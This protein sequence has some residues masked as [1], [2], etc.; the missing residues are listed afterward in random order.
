MHQQL[1][2]LRTITAVRLLA[3]LELH[4]ANDAAL[5]TGNPQ[6]Q[7]TFGQGRPQT[8]EVAFGVFVRIKVS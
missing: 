6:Q 8:V 2:Y 7:F 1:H 3:E 5:V 4:G